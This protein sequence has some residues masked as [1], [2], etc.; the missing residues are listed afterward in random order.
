MKWRLLGRIKLLLARS[1]E[2]SS[3]PRLGKCLNGPLLGWAVMNRV[4]I[5]VFTAHISYSF[6]LFTTRKA[7]PRHTPYHYSGKAVVGCHTLPYRL[8]NLGYED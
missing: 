3:G 4:P 1:R 8:N 7:L 2:E 5:S 6:Y